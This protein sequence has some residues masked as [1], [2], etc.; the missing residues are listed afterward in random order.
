M[1]VS[2]YL[3]MNSE[4]VSVLFNSNFLKLPALLDMNTE[5]SVVLFG[6]NSLLLDMNFEKVSIV[7]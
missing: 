3:H 6:S 4:K 7:W 1:K 2:V 5:K